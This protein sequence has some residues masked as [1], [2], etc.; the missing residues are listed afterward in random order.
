MKVSVS[1]VHPLDE[2]L[3]LGRLDPPLAAAADLDGLQLLAPDQGVDLRARGVEHLGHVGQRQEARR[4]PAAVDHAGHRLIPAPRRWRYPAGACGWTSSGDGADRGH[5]G[6]VSRNLGSS[7]AHA[8]PCR[9]PY[10][11][12]GRGGVTRGCGSASSSSPS[13]SWPALALLAAAD[14]SVTVWAAARDMGAGD[15]VTADDVVVRRVRFDDGADLDHYFG[16]DAALPAG[17]PAA[18]RRGRRRAVAAGG[19]R[20]GRRGR[21][22]PAAGGRR[23]RAGAAVGGRRFAIDRRLPVLTVGRRRVARPAMRTRPHGR[24]GRRGLVGRRRL[25]G[26]RQ[27]AAR[28][29]RRPAATPARSSRRSAAATGRPSSPSSGGAEVVVVVLILASGAAWESAAADGLLERE[30]GVVVLRRCVDV[31]DLLAAASAGQADVAVVAL[32]APGLD[33]DA[34]DHLR[35]FQVRPRS[36]SCRRP[37]RRARAAGRP[38]R[39][40]RAPSPTTTSTS[41]RPPSGPTTPRPRPTP[42]CPDPVDSRPRPGGRR[43]RG[44][45]SGRRPG[46]D[47]GGGG[48]WPPSWRHGDGVR[49]SSTPTRTA[50]P[51]PSSSASSTRS[52]ACSPRPGWP[53]RVGWRRGSGRCSASWATTSPW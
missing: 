11:P 27:A 36:W 1:V 42:S 43:G 12:P 8:R 23:R 29:R 49:R 52:R 9:W 53:G 47:H 13:R 19:R 48:R 40:D 21:P 51:S 28:A 33:L 22:A 15:T 34:V 16:A 39:R 32:E 7:G 46:T 14:D 4:P 44:V 17:P 37:G 38:A 3:E 20:S 2:G 35:R 10:V 50:A 26:L 18:A 5:D 25:R 45:G 6:G 31:P 41:C 30:S 24:H